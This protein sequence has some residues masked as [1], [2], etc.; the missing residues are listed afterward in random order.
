MTYFSEANHSTTEFPFGDPAVMAW[1]F[2][3]EEKSGHTAVIPEVEIQ[4]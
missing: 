3:Q 2:S 4:K 1:L